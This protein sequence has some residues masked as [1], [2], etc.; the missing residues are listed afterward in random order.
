MHEYALVQNLLDQVG[1]QAAALHATA[2]RK[3]TVGMGELAGVNPDLF[4][5]AFETFRAGGGVCQDAELSIH[6]VK[7]RW[8]CSQCA[9]VI[10]RG[11]VLRCPNCGV[12]ARLAAGDELTLERIELEVPDAQDLRGDGAAGASAA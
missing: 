6:W 4:A 7:A 9:H 1:A 10:Q 5:T 2:V 8:V 12:P 3:V 11:A